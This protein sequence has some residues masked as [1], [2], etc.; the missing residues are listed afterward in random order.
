MTGPRVMIID[1][2]PCLVLT[3]PNDLTE[4]AELMDR[5]DKQAIYR[6]R[7]PTPSVA[8]F[9]AA[10]RHVAALA[11]LVPVAEL[12]RAPDSPDGAHWISTTDAA[13]TLGVTDRAIRKRLARG[14]LQGQQIAGRWWIDLRNLDA[15]S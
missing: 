14:T 15:A 9:V 7:L 1:Q 8:P 3:D 10:A 4:L 11:Q 12:S 6:R 2:V 13:E 5:T